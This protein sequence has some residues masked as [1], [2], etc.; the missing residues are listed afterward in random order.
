MKY[1]NFKQAKNIVEQ[2]DSHQEKLKE[3]G[4]YNVKV[5]VSNNSGTIYTIGVDPD[6]EH[7]YA[8]A[9]RILTN[10]MRDDLKFR[11]EQLKSILL[12]L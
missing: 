6:S 2:I 5:A 10:A 3:L 1:E 7:Q 12:E 11:I 9:A 4:T 8:E